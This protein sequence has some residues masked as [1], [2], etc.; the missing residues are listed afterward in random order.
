[1]LLTEPEG[2]NIAGYDPDLAARLIVEAADLI[3]S[4]GFMADHLVLIGGL[5][6]GLLIPVLDPEI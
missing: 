6:P 2:Q 3:R 1:M 5:V 4:L